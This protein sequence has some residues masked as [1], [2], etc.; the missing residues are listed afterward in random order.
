MNTVERLSE[1]VNSPRLR[2]NSKSFVES[3]LAQAKGKELSAKQMEYVDKFWA[4]CFPPEEIVLAEKEW[5]DSF[6]D[7]KREK[8]RIVGEYYERHYPNSRIA[9][10]HKDP[11]WIPDREIFEKSIASAWASTLVTNYKKDYRFNA[12]DTCVLR[13]TQ[14]NRS[15]YRNMVG[16]HLLILD[17]KKDVEHNFKNS[18]NVIEI[19]K[20]E[21]QKTF[22]VSEDKVNVYKEKKVKNG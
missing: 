19:S 1:I 5:R 6:D 7:E 14:L 17:C 3:L 15:H 22:W 4:E 10:N 21:D 20:M 8:L 9:K 13:D 11:N 18:Y 2:Q 16:E 12:G